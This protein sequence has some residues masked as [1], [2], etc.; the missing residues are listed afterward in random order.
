MLCIQEVRVV[1]NASSMS[2]ENNSPVPEVIKH[3]EWVLY[4]K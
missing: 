3:N 1:D 4:L 2:Q